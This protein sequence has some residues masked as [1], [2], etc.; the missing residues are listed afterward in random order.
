MEDLEREFGGEQPKT[1]HTHESNPP[2]P[3]KIPLPADVTANTST[4]AKLRK[5]A[6]RGTDQSERPRTR[7]SL[8]DLDADDVAIYGGDSMSTDQSERSTESR[9]DI[10]VDRRSRSQSRASTEDHL[11]RE[12]ESLQRQ[13][14]DAN[15]RAEQA[16]RA[17]EELQHRAKVVSSG[18]E[19]VAGDTDVLCGMMGDVKA[20]NKKLKA[21]LDDARSH[22][23]SLQSYRKDLT[24][25]EVG[26]DFDDLVNNITDWVSKFV[27]PILDDPVKAEEVLANA[28][29]RTADL[30]HLRTT[31]ARHGDLVNA[32]MFPDTDIDVI[33]AITMRFLQ[34]NVFQ[35]ILFGTLPGV[36]EALTFVEG[37]M[38][39]N[40]EPKRDLFALRSWRAEA[41]NA[42]INSPIYRQERATRMRELTV[43][44][45]TMLRMFRRDKEWNKSCF[46][47][48]DNVIRPAIDFH[49][50][51]LT[52]THH[53]YL[54]LNPYIMWNARQEL[55]MSPDFIENLPRLKC[56]NILQNRKPFVLAKLDPQPTK[57]EL[58]EDL[59]NIVTVIPALYMRQIGK[60]DAIK[61]PTIVRK[62]QVLVAWG[63]AEKR[64]KFVANSERTI[65]NRLYYSAAKTER[66]YENVWAQWKHLAVG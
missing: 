43:E 57:A 37:S 6:R 5:P 3:P 16:E 11:L 14:L 44:L 2:K 53:F 25:E 34:D 7:G 51:L 39:T 65:M 23:F 27:D 28:K 56:E 41:I 54:D 13:L 59:A 29:K 48:Q 17:A 38:Q 58:F 20:E 30:R 40:V 50:K 32:C 64:E 1:A 49:E 18:I 66:A 45:N 33:I 60:G 36:V 47:C 26:R 15:S 55:E 35:K 22:I 61:T 31:M 24:P 4:H 19:E 46:A 42:V 9:D 21:E 52:S 8:V 12:I 62:Q 63:N 10:D